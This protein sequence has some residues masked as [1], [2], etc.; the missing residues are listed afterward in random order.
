ML[1]AL[2]TA[3]SPLWNNHKTRN[4][5]IGDK[6]S[7]P[8]SGGMIFLNG[9]SIGSKILPRNSPNFDSLRAGS[10]ELKMYMMSPHLS[11]VMAKN[12]ICAIIPTKLSSSDL[13]KIILL[14]FPLSFLYLKRFHL[15]LKHFLVCRGKYHF[16]PFGYLHLMHKRY[17]LKS[18]QSSF[19]ALNLL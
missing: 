9:S 17:R 8:P 15:R 3:T 16:R 13:S 4:N 1:S 19:S 18:L 10:Q 14:T 2:N 5:M 11:N 7:M 6:S 12:D